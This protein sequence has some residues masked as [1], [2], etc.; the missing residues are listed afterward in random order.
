MANKSAPKETGGIPPLDYFDL[1]CVAPQMVAYTLRNKHYAPFKAGAEVKLACSIAERS[2]ATMRRVI[3]ERFYKKAAAPVSR[4]LEF[5]S[6]LVA[7]H[8]TNLY[9]PRPYQYI[10]IAPP[11]GSMT[12]LS[13]ILD[14]PLLPL[15]YRMALLHEKPI[16]ADIAA[17]YLQASKKVADKFLEKDPDVEI[18]SEYD[19]I[20]ER[21]RVT[22]AAL[23][24]FKF[25]TIPRAYLNFIRS[26]LAPGGSVILVESRIGWRQFTVAKDFTF[27]IGLSG[28]ISDEEFIRGSKR[29]TAFREKHLNYKNVT[30]KI[31]CADELKPE[32]RF[33]VSPTL[34][35]SVLNSAEEIKRPVC[36]LYS[37]D[38]YQINNLV[39]SLYIRAARR[40]GKRPARLLIHSGIFL[41]PKEC[42]DSLI[43]PV[44]VPDSSYAS[45]DFVNKYLSSYQFQT[46]SVF[47]ALEPGIASPPD[48]I[49]YKKW[50]DMISQKCAARTV[51]NKPRLFP[52]DMSAY[53]SFWPSVK[54]ASS[55]IKDPLDVRVNLDMLIEEAEKCLIHFSM[56]Q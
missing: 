45:F 16:E 10:I 27:Q 20:H 41:S 11:L 6:G 33:G 13:S 55:K 53:F 31:K 3:F 17:D 34:R 25:K 12:Y 8:F 4:A 49:E 32:S 14:A 7:N 30:Y 35:T 28:G 22:R 52:V 51:G 47:L 50:R 43:L 39:S 9:A 2:G 40:A 15:N 44:W 29:I 5:R 37:N 36:Q 56:H 21:L 1:S 46:E 54:A 18:V 48:V 38:I 26:N 23:L 24:R 19:P 42:N